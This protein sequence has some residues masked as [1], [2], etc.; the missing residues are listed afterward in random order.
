M[1]AEPQSVERDRDRAG[2]RAARRLSIERCE[3][4]RWTYAAPRKISQAKTSTANSS[5]QL[6]GAPST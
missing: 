6:I 3:S 1:T 5:A 2:W 4:S